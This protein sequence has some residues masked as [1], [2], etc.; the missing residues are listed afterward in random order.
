MVFPLQNADSILSFGWLPPESKYSRRDEASPEVVPMDLK[1]LI[2]QLEVPSSNLIHNW[3]GFSG[4]AASFSLAQLMSDSDHFFIF[5]ASG[6]EEVQSVANE[7]KFFGSPKLS[8][9]TIPEW[10]TLPY[11][12][13]S[14]HDDLI[15]ERLATSFELLYADKGAL[16][17]SIRSLLQ[18][19]PPSQFVRSRTFLFEPGQRFDIQS[20]SLRL[21]QT[22]Y[23]YVELVMERGEFSVRGSLMDIYPMGSDLPIRIDLDDEVI[24]GIRSFEP[25]S[26]RTI[27]R[28][29][30]VRLLPAKEFPLDQDAIARFRESWHETFD[31]DV[32][33]CP[34]YQEVNEGIGAQGLEYYLPLF[35]ENTETLFDYLPRDCVFVLSDNVEASASHFWKEL[36]ARYESL[37]H[38]IERPILP[39]E[40][41]FQKWPAV[42]KL[43][44]EHGVIQLDPV[45]RETGMC[46]NW[47]HV[48]CPRSE[49]N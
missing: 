29:E 12:S 33:R 44:R 31:V 5:V 48:Q 18:C 1:R 23:R 47:A 19:M 8:V 6:S 36:V 38:D 3:Q 40:R 15:S 22:G 39:P 9:R 24:D 41:L 30:T 17:V 2:K 25:D 16:V 49:R 10:E 35:F 26:Q 14:P 4:S 42:S 43:I 37:R 27:A 21:T 46:V 32:R 28:L 34:I 7:L 45:V 11:D 20:E 13:F